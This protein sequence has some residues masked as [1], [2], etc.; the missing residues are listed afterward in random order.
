M[1]VFSSGIAN[2]LF[3]RMENKL[4]EHIERLEPF[5]LVVGIE[6]SGYN[7]HILSGQNEDELGETLKKTSIDKELVSKLSRKIGTESCFK[8]HL[9]HVPAEL[10]KYQWK[11]WEEFQEK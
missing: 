9:V 4:P 5:F 7:D 1:K 11:K 2:F 10:S 6:C 8:C 3:H